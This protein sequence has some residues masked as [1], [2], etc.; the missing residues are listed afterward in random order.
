VNY[1]LTPTTARLAAQ[2]AYAVLDPLVDALL[3]QLRDAWEMHLRLLAENPRYAAA[4]AAGT[5]ALMGH[6]SPLDLIAAI[7]AALLAIYSATR[8]VVAYL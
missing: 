7:T 8:K 3:E 4:I 6:S 2:A 5:A 1:A